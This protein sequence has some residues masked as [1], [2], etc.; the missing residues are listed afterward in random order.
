MDPIRPGERLTRYVL[1]SSYYRSL[2]KTVKH[3]AFLPNSTG[4]TSVFRTSGLDE[5][6][7]R[8]I[9]TRFVA[10]PLK[11][12]LLGWVN[13][14][15]DD[16]LSNNLRIDPDDEP[17]RHANIIGWPSDRPEQNLIARILAANARLHINFS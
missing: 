5:E 17:P 1:T 12:T 10:G 13:I 8:D 16:V 9:G 15:V 11:K 4:Q 2:D 3:T 6:A 7:I 14:S